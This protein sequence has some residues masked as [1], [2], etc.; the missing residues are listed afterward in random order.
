MCTGRACG[1][2]RWEPP[3]FP[4]P[5]FLPSPLPVGGP[6]SDRPP[7]GRPTHRPS[8]RL[9]HVF[10]ARGSFLHHCLL[11]APPTSSDKPPFDRPPLCLSYSFSFCH[12]ALR[13]LSVHPS[14]HPWHCRDPS[15]APGGARQRVMPSYTNPGVHYRVGLCSSY[16]HFH[17]L[18]FPFAQ[19]GGAH[20][21]IGHCPGTTL[22]P[23]PRTLHQR[24]QQ[25]SS[26]LK[27]PNDSGDMCRY[28][29]TP[30]CRCADS[31]RCRCADVPIPSSEVLRVY[32]SSP[33]SKKVITEPH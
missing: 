5:G 33:W 8:V 15:Q 11:V 6:P 17:P 1:A 14:I 30:R 2:G 7:F 19:C 31:P 18:P 10:P 24:E 26:C 9:S 22:G 3:C 20:D 12:F 27:L 4:R 25:H 32:S 16:H 21:M 13:S 23:G 29:D 28:A